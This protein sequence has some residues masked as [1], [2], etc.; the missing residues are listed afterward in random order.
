MIR[1]LE[2]EAPLL[3][4]LHNGQE[5]PIVCVVVLFG[6]CAFSRVEVYR[7]ENPKTVILVENV[8]YGEAAC[9]GLHNNRLCRIEIVEDWCISEGPF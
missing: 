4:S 9:I 8:G 6:T 2:V 3:H 1:S 7:S 5:I